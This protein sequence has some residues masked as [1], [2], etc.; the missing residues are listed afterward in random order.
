MAAIADDVLTLWHLIN[1]RLLVEF[2][3]PTVWERLPWALLAFGTAIGGLIVVYVLVK[4]ILG[5]CCLPSKYN[6]RLVWS[7]TN[8]QGKD[9]YKRETRNTS[10]S[11]KHV[12]LETLFFVGCFIVL[13]IASFVAGFNLMSSSLMSIGIGLVA[14]YMFGVVIQN[15]GSGYWVYVTDKFEEFQYVRSATNPLVHGLI[16]EMHPMF[17]ILQQEKEEGGGLLEIQ[18]PM[19]DMLS[20]TW[21]RDFAAEAKARRWRMEMDRKELENDGY[22][23]EDIEAIYNNVDE[24][25]PLP[26]KMGSGGGGGGGKLPL[27]R[28]I[29]GLWRPSKKGGGVRNALKMV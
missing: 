2:T 12:I 24:G 6:D 29:R 18:V 5:Y 10:G 17:V 23:E 8:E 19:T 11:Y 3:G 4:V 15:M 1:P 14:T 21:I 22:L 13:W 20:G 7:G 27:T 16:N 25:L 28:A 26:A 9:V